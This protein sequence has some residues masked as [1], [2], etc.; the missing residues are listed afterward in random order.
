MRPAPGGSHH[1]CG[2]RQVRCFALARCYCAALIAFGFGGITRRCIAGQAPSRKLWHTR[3]RRQCWGAGLHHPT[4]AATH[5][6]TTHSSRSCFATRL[7]SSVRPRQASGGILMKIQHAVA[8]GLVVTI[9]SGCATVTYGDKSAEATLRELQP[10]P[11][12]V[13]LYVCREKA[14]F[15]GAGNRTTAIVDNKPIGTLKPN[16]FAHVVVEP[17]PH[18][19]YIEHNPGGKSGVL[20]LDTRAD[21]VPIIWVGMTGHGWGVLTVDQFKSRS[22]AESCVRQGQY[23]IPTE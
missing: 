20:N 17:G 2:L 5:C 18:S 22:E 8:A 16:N 6:L 7:N 11:G 10:V 21:E 15:V 14:A 9:M 4:F 13:S 19:V 23:A 12:R 3:S 1:C